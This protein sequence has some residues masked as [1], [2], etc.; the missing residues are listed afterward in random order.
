[1]SQSAA[2]LTRALALA[3]AF[4]DSPLAGVLSTPEALREARFFF[5]QKDIMVSGVMDLVAKEEDLWRI[6]DYKTN[7]LAGRSPAQVA[8]EYELQGVV[9][10][11]AALLAGAPAVRLDFLFLERPAE[12]QA[13]QFSRGDISRLKNRLDEVLAGLRRAEY[14]LAPDEHC[15]YC[16]AAE[17]CAGMARS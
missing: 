2:E 16:A 17:V 13:V 9:Y 1:V 8:S 5:A 12:P 15:R 4:W 3:R 14:P 6:V 7:A 11:L 10:S